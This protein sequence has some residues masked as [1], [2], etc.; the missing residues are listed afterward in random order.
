MADDLQTEF[1]IVKRGII[2]DLLQCLDHHTSEGLI[3]ETIRFI[4]KLS[5]ITENRKAMVKV[6]FNKIFFKNI[7]YDLS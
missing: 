4:W 5:V 3:L 2:T 1:K 6:I 7:K